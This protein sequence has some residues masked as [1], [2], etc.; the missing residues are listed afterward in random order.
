MLG[1]EAA[2]VLL[3]AEPVAALAPGSPLGSLTFVPVLPKRF[4]LP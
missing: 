4:R 2:E 1:E 3:V